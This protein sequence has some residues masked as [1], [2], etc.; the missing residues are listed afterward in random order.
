MKARR[1]F[2]FMRKEALEIIRD[3]IT[4]GIALFMPLLMLFLFA[5]AISLDVENAPLVIVD[6]DKS[7]AGSV[8]LS[9]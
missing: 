4:V 9:V 3:P 2:A 5:Y 8:R 6:H 1:T 7:A